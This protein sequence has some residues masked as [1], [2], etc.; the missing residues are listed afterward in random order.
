M[1]ANKQQV[2]DQIKADILS[3][4]VCPNL[5]QEATNIV[6]GHGNLN[7]NILFIG[8]APGK[9][10]DLTGIPF[11]GAAGK[12]LDSLLKSV[13][14]AR[15]E[16]FIT[17]IV[18]YRPPKNRD[19]SIKEKTDFAPYLIREIQLVQ[20]T[21]IVTLGRHSLNYFADSQEIGKIHGK[22]IEL[23][24]SDIAYRFLPLYHPAAAIYNRSLEKVLL[25]DIRKLKKYIN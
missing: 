24:V 13:D 14:L 23:K 12:L 11:V 16:V 5:A 9:K 4:N 21:V 17:N 6:M 3:N 20:P 8:E 22:F 7:S 19:P 1:K 15:D 18:K 25:Q 10:E 2:L